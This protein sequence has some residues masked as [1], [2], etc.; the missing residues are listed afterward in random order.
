PHPVDSQTHQVQRERAQVLEDPHGQGRGA[1][2]TIGAQA[3]VEV[4]VVVLYGEVGA[5]RLGCVGVEHGHR[6]R[7]S[8]SS[9]GAS[10][11]ST[12]GLTMMRAWDGSD[13]PH[14]TRVAGPRVAASPRWAGGRMPLLGPRL[15]S[16]S[17]VT[18]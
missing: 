6:L 13:S 10:I 3:V 15:A 11:T 14:M 9:A 4:E 2:Q 16:S 1:G 5:A 17:S 18:V 8:S 7:A 12:T